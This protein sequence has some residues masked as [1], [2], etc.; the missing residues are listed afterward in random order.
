MSD[1]ETE[2]KI[3]AKGRFAGLLMAGT[4]VLWLV[5]QAIGPRIG[6]S[7]RWAALF[8][9]IALASFTCALIVTYQIWRLRRDDKG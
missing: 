6:L 3:Q 4:M 7:M 1:P 2:R 9:F 5:A 8:D